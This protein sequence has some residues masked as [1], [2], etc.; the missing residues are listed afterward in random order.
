MGL[1]PGEIEDMEW[2]G[3]T[4]TF[5]DNVSDYILTFSLRT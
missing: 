1:C 4:L 3:R 2:Y 5:S